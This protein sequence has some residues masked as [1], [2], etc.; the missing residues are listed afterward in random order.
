MIQDNIRD[1]N[2]NVIKE[3]EKAASSDF[4]I[5]KVY[6]A[7]LTSIEGSIIADM[8]QMSYELVKPVVFVHRAP[9]S[10]KK[11][12]KA[13]K[14]SGTEVLYDANWRQQRNQNGVGLS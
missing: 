10:S 3:D 9:S 12:I 8:L 7:K 11:K 5:A 1:K 6:G 14:A 13:I 2:N 4:A